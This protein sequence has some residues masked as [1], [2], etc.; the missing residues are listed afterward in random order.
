MYYFVFESHGRSGIAIAEQQ[1]YLSALHGKS[2]LGV[3]M[4]CNSIYRPPNL[5]LQS[6]CTC[7]TRWKCTGVNN[8]LS[9]LNVKLIRIDSKWRARQRHQAYID[10]SNDP[11]EM[12]SCIIPVLAD[13][14]IPNGDT[15]F[16][17]AS[18]RDGLADLQCQHVNKFLGRSESRVL[19]YSSTIQLLSEIS[20]IFPPNW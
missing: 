10:V 12:T 2:L 8:I 1:G 11:R 9:L 14:K 5:L 19:P 7:L 20:V 16:K 6:S 15:S 13:S 18:I 3:L 4:I 17:N